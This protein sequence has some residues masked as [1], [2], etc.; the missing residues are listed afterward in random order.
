MWRARGPSGT[1]YQFE[2]PV[3]LVSRDG[4]ESQG[5]IDLDKAGH[6]VL[7]AKD[8]LA[9]SDDATKLRKAYGQACADPSAVPGGPPPSSWCRTWAARWT[10]DDNAI[11]SR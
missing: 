1:G 11:A 7:E 8:Q 6:F 5:F 10:A 3:K 4:Q 2:F 9:T